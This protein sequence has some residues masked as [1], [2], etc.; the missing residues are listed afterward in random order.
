[1]IQDWHG[2]AQE[3]KNYRYYQNINIQKYKYEDLLQQEEKE[4]KA[5]I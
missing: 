4:K 2:N 3:K 5:N 1:M